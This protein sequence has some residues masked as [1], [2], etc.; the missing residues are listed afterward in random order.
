MLRA[1][2]TAHGTP[3]PAI[4]KALDYAQ[5][6]LGIERLLLSRELCT[7]KRELCFDRC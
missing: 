1:L 4:R 5:T 6:D 7:D 2:R 3:I